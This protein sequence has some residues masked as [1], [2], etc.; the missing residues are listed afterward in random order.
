MKKKENVAVKEKL[1]NYI[2]PEIKIEKFSKAFYME[3]T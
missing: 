2:K 1:R 3:M